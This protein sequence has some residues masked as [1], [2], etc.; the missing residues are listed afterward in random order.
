MKVMA[1]APYEG[2]KELLL[3]LGED[4]P[5]DLQVEYGDLEEGVHLAKQAVNNGTDIIIS[6]GG[7]AELIQKVVSIP[8]IDIEVS[9]YDL[10]RVLTLVKEYTGKTAIVGFP[11]IS[12]GAATIC[13]IA[14]IEL[15]TY[16]V[17][18]E[19]EVE[20]T[21]L[22]LHKKGYDMFIGDVITVKKA[23]NLGFNAILITAGKESVHKAFQQ[24]KKTHH[25]YSAL[26]QNYAMAR[27]ILDH[28]QAGI[29]VYNRSGQVVFTN[30]DFKEKYLDL[31]AKVIDLESALQTAFKQETF[32]TFVQR[33]EEVWKVTAFPMQKDFIVF[34]VIDVTNENA[35][36]GTTLLPSSN[37]SN[38]ASHHTKM[39]HALHL[40]EIYRDRDEPIWI[41][42]EVGTGKEK[43]AHFI[44][45]SSKREPYPLLR[46]DCEIVQEEQ[47]LQL[48]NIE[49][50]DATLLHHEMGSVL[51][52][53]IDA[54]TLSIQKRL[55][56][57]LGTKEVGCRFIATSREPYQTLLAQGVFLE[58]LYYKMARLTIHL[59]SLNE[60]KEDIEN[61]TLLFISKYN[62]K[63]GK[64][65]VGLRQ[66]AKEALENFRWSGNINQLKQVI[67]EIVL[68]S[69]DPYI[70]VEDVEAILK[71]KRSATF[72]GS[73][74]LN[75]TLEEIERRIIKQVWE[76]EG[77]NQ[78]R[79]AK[80]LGINRT[81][82]WRKMNLPRLR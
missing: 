25:L 1:I 33:A 38:M 52:K 18:N 57:L 77:R 63:F 48:L 53:N 43:L 14:N 8:V 39:K 41:E 61:L 70:A 59:P 47:W 75:G 15:S 34:R 68:I 72:Q 10:L 46:I 51:L 66:E 12:E 22:E 78:T 29:V 24:A 5:F 56:R 79:T 69:E 50:P 40:A 35:L 44:H 58:E 16:T 17:K 74:S 31:F 55:L 3:Q 42:G 20:P 36:T 11:P 81:T 4:E 27:Q 2:L 30:R 82:L 73:L 60:R 37:H 54:L 65:C 49:H 9:G 45:S 62:Q 23:A 32:K 76:E 21:L 67:E 7:T 64:Q 19:H 13:E 28:Y 6:R 80:R 26:K 71:T